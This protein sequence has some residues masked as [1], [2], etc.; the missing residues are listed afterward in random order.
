[1]GLD[2]RLGAGGVGGVGQG[3]VGGGQGGGLGVGLG[4]GFG[5]G[6]E[7]AAQLLARRRVGA[8]L[9]HRQGASG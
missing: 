8:Q 5:F 7:A 4:F 1:M 3:G 6:L 2:T 9:L